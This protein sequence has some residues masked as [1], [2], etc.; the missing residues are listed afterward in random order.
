MGVF[1]VPAKTEAVL[2]V[3]PDRV[4]AFAVLGEPMEFVSGWHLKEIQ[5][6]R[7][8]ELAKLA[9]SDGMKIGRKLLCSPA[10]PDRFCR[11]GGEA[12]DH[13]E[14]IARELLA[15]SASNGA[16]P[17][18]RPSIPGNSFVTNCLTN[19]NKTGGPNQELRV[20]YGT[21]FWGPFG[22]RFSRCN[23]AE[24]PKANGGC[25]AQ[26]RGLLC[27]AIEGRYPIL[28]RRARPDDE[29]TGL[30]CD[31]TIRLNSRNG[32]KAY[33]E[34]LRRIS[35]V[36]PESG[37]HCLGWAFSRFA[38]RGTGAL[39]RRPKPDPKSTNPPPVRKARSQ[40]GCDDGRRQAASLGPHS[41]R[42]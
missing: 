17:R 7:G 41:R 2:A 33:P 37:V 18:S 28:L 26:G 38:D 34:S 8:I 36:D 1:A 6:C 3:H 20:P 4:L 40:T 11:L 21:G 39:P 12:L 35:Y 29:T 30:R 19:T 27:H 31:Q 23:A 16:F 42:P 10:T 14:M 32:K 24:R 13:R 22:A 25:D 15:S 5:F 9:Q